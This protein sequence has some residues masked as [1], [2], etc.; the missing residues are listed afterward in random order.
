MSKRIA[1][2]P[3]GLWWK[4]HGMPKYE[5]LSI[6]RAVREQMPCQERA[7]YTANC[8]EY[9]CVCGEIGLRQL[10]ESRGLDRDPDPDFVDVVFVALDVDGL[11]EWGRVNQVGSLDAQ[12]RR[13]T[14][15]RKMR[16][17]SQRFLFGDTVLNEADMFS[18]VSLE[19]LAPRD[20][21]EGQPRKVIL[22]GHGLHNDIRRLAAL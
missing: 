12:L 19:D 2:L 9:F 21:Q 5:Y 8:D 16:K 14:T 17:K 1:C 10:R 4:D 6:G 22:V 7:H 18:Q 13:V 3:L 15:S 20:D 11:D